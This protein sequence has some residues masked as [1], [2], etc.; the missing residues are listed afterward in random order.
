MEPKGFSDLSACI[1]G[2]KY[3]AVAVV[4]DL[5]APNA[6]SKHQALLL[7]LLH[8]GSTTKPGYFCSPQSSLNLWLSL[9]QL[10]CHTVTWSEQDRSVC[11]SRAKTYFEGIM[12]K[13]AAGRTE[14]SSPCFRSKPAHVLPVRKGQ[15][16]RCPYICPSSPSTTQL[17]CL[18]CIR[19][20]TVG[21]K[22]PSQG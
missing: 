21:L 15:V 7:F 12:R 4:R 16:S 19:P 17:A 1:L 13:S 22:N 14:F 8:P 5:A 2:A 10:Q 11:F 6:L 3:H 20:Q 9:L 18:P